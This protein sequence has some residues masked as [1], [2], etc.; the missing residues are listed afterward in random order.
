VL[1][2]RNRSANLQRLA[3]GKP[4]LPEESRLLAA[5]DA[6]LPASTGVALGFDRLAM[7]AAGAS[8]LAKVLAFPIDRA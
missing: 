3:D 1:R 6:G 5:M 7:L 2:E 4:A 8:T